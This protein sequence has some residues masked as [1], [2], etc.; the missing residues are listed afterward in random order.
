MSFIKKFVLAGLLTCCAAALAA[1]ST[2][3][4]AGALFGNEVAF[5]ELQL[6]QSLGRKFPREYEHLGGLVSVTLMNPRLSIPP[7]A[8]R[9]RVDFDVGVAGPGGDSGVPDGRFALTSALRYDPASRGLHLLEP[10]I[11]HVDIPSL[12]GVMND[13]ARSA[14]NRWLV[15]YARNEPVYRFDDSLL[16]RL[17]SRRIADTRI[18]SGRVVVHLGN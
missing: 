13:A 10:S 4:A 18:E 11:E 9:L 16:G 6:Q 12:G 5:T 1:C 15:D 8:S 7:G 14:L 3:G 2:L 17:G